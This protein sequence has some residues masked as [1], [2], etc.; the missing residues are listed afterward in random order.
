LFLG[1]EVFM[2]YEDL[3]AY[4]TKIWTGGIL[5]TDHGS[6]CKTLAVLLVISGVGKNAGPCVEAEKIMQ[7]VCSRCNRN[8][9]S[10]TECDTCGQCCGHVKA[11]VAESG[12][13]IRDKYT[14]ER[15]RLLEEKLQNALL[16]I[17]ELTGT[18]RTDTIGG[19]WKGI[20][21]AGYCAGSSSKW[22][23]L[24]VG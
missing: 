5:L 24:S 17:D 18:G 19:S 4:C 11:Q 7:V 22:R 10:G 6:E 20:W 15:L 8:H 1:G 3:L 9:K 13:W 14:S 23:L 16:Q 2:G 21:K 12:K